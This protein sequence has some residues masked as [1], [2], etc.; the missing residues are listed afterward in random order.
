VL[1]TFTGMLGAV[2]REEPGP[3]CEEDQLRA[4]LGE[5]AL[6]ESAL[7]ESALRESG[8]DAAA[9]AGATA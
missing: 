3:C 2:E 7:G 1:E 6:G 8:S 5:S 4:A 9:G